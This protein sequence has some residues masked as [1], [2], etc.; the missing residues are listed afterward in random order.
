M[1]VIVRTRGVELSERLRSMTRRKLENLERFA[2]DAERV[3]VDFA[4]QRNPRI[5][6]H[7][8][9][10]ARLHLRHGVLT[11]HADAPE[12]EAALDLVIA[13]LRNQAERR[14]DRRVTAR[15]RTRG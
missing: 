13:K 4:D 3:E 10:A 7:A 5:A 11:A 2:R 6:D 15:G 12:P 14:K 9:C 8:R 1:Q